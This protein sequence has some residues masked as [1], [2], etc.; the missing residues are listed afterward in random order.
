MK[1]TVRERERGTSCQRNLVHI[2]TGKLD[3]SVVVKDCCFYTH[4]KDGSTSAAGDKHV[5]IQRPTPL[6]A[7]NKKLEGEWRRPE[8]Q[9]PSAAADREKAKQ[10]SGS[11]SRNR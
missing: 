2:F 5:P 3:V 1:G 8:P 10:G 7:S 6:T 4:G 11:G 9:S